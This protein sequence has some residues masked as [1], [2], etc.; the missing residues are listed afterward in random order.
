MQSII[1]DCKVDYAFRVS[2]H[3][4]LLVEYEDRF[5]FSE[6]GIGLQGTCPAET[7]T[8]RRPMF[9]WDKVNKDI[10]HNYISPLRNCLQSLT[11]P[12]CKSENI[13]CNVHTGF[14]CFDSYY[15]C[16]MQAISESCE[17]FIPKQC[18][19]KDTDVC[20]K[21]EV[22][23]WNGNVKVHHAATRRAYKLWNGCGRPKNGPVYDDMCLTRRVFKNSLWQCRRNIENE[24]ANRL[25]NRFADKDHKGF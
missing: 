3:L 20:E 21:N 6:V 10:E 13:M 12:D 15:S 25:A 5:G 23:G 18:S 19:Y 16:I 9:K 24:K 8:G 7:S 4:P 22:I 11:V 14:E 17:L 2:D 1:V